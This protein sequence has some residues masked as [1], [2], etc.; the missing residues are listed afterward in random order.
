MHMYQQAQQARTQDITSH[1]H[2][3]RHAPTLVSHQPQPANKTYLTSPSRTHTCMHHRHTENK[4]IITQPACRQHTTTRKGPLTLILPSPRTA[5]NHPKFA[6]YSP[7]TVPPPLKPAPW[8]PGRE[9][10]KR[11]AAQPAILFHWKA[12]DGPDSGR[13]A[14]RK[15][16]KRS[17]ESI[18]DLHLLLF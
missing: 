9:S 4:A 10:S 13:S 3:Y 18:A 6:P 7:H 5:S 2:T 16:I 17:Q 12:I 14:T 8:C 11:N 15:S 1:V